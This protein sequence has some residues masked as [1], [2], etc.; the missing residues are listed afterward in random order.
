MKWKHAVNK[1]CGGWGCQR[2]FWCT[3]VA[4]VCTRPPQT[5][6]LSI[7]LVKQ[8]RWFVLFSEK[9]TSNN[10]TTALFSSFIWIFSNEF[11]VVTAVKRDAAVITLNVAQ[12]FLRTPIYHCWIII[13]IAVAFAK[14]SLERLR[15]SSSGGWFQLT[16]YL[17]PAKRPL[18]NKPIMLRKKPNHLSNN[19]GFFCFKQTLCEISIRA[20]KL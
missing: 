14:L 20:S 4:E 7:R 10:I 15:C 6:P 3:Y 2:H 11:R 18:R 5:P 1:C 13:D 12:Q 9:K 17:Q 8:I 19:N 16:V